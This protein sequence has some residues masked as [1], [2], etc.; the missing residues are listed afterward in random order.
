MARSVA[1]DESLRV[2]VS[3]AA[4][5]VA[6]PVGEGSDCCR[7]LVVARS[8]GRVRRTSSG[9]IVVDAEASGATQLSE[10]QVRSAG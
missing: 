3:R 5:A 10:T 7:D 2:T 4:V 6:A 9:G 1:E 8:K